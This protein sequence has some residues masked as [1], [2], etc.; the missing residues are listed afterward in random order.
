MIVKIHKKEN[1]LTSG[2]RLRKGWGWIKG[3]S[4]LD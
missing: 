4:E 1:N 2:V 3:E